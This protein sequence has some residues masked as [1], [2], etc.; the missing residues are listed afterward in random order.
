MSFTALAAFRKVADMLPEDVP[1]ILETVVPEGQIEL[2]M[3]LAQ[4]VFD[5]V[6]MAS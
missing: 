3:R 1:V 6:A 5:R 4:S 2:Q